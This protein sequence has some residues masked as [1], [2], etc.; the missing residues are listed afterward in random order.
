[1]RVGLYLPLFSGETERVLSFARRAESL[2]FDGLF[3]FDHLFPP[4]APRDRPSLE[5][6]SMLAAVAAATNRVA[7]GTLVARAPL[8][9]AGM[10]AR[11]AST[12]QD[13]SDGRMILGLGAGDPGNPEHGVFGIAAPEEGDR[14]AHLGETARC[15]RALLHGGAWSGGSHVP[16]VHGPLLPRSLG[17]PPVW[18]GGSSDEIVRLAG[19]EADGWNGW[20]LGIDVFERKV[21]ALRDAAGDGPAEATWAGIAVVG[22]DDK[23]LA[24]LLERREQRRRDAR[25]WAGTTASLRDRLRGL[26]RAGASWSVLALAGP[27]DR[28]EVSAEV[29][30]TH[31][32]SA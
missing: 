30:A 32:R 31:G 13:L 16:A 23:E 10:T 28:L 29:L 20:Q 19:L 24:H 18:I 27:P 21:A 1:M 8:R 7:I 15:V 3:A 25:V 14:H 6:F 5:A 22:R 26:E 2:G 4:G 12:L 9:S 11:L 17:G